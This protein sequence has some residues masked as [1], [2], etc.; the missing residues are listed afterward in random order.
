MSADE[1]EAEGGDTAS[2][3]V[4]TAYLLTRDGDRALTLVIKSID[5]ALR[6]GPGPEPEAVL[7]ATVRTWVSQKRSRAA[8]PAVVRLDNGPALTEDDLWTRLATLPHDQQATLV[9]RHHDGHNPAEVATMLNRDSGDVEKLTHA[10]ETALGQPDPADLVALLR[11]H[12]ED[13][14]D[15]SELPGRLRQ[16]RSRRRRRRIGA[17]AAAAIV[18][19]AA[20]AVPVA[21]SSRTLTG[22]GHVTP[23]AKAVQ[24]RD[25]GKLVGTASLDT[26]KTKQVSVT[27][28]PTAKPIIPV[29]HCTD[30][31][32]TVTV[33]GNRKPL[34]G[35]SCSVSASLGAN[36]QPLPFPLGKPA[37]ITLTINSGGGLAQLAVYQGVP[38]DEYVFPPRPAKLAPPP[39]GTGPALA[40][41]TKLGANAK[42]TVNLIL[43]ANTQ[44]SAIT[45]A[46]GELR[47]S[48]DGTLVRTLTSWDWPPHFFT[49]LLT[50]DDLARR[51][52]KVKAGQSVRITMQASRF[53]VPGWVVNKAG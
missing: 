23:I 44:L 28:T 20:V 3:W 46:P 34:F 24:Y 14:P 31:T 27:F 18:L 43:G 13:A 4:R 6:A 40:D 38:L 48:V 33:A 37:T 15:P 1:P 5:T 16:R 25:G 2:A 21:R 45:G 42:A 35:G 22:T 41:S 50:P 10:A 8:A 32:A 53:D 36:G 12:A 29:A 52:I 11:T 7:Q 26:A 30:L 9:L 19:L 49:V 39:N 51:G 47:I 17:L